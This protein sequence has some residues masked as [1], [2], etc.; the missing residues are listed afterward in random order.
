LRALLG[1]ECPASTV[2]VKAK[3]DGRVANL[4][5]HP[6]GL[7]IGLDEEDAAV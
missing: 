3:P 2:G 4:D 6:S 1:R 7:G 5:A